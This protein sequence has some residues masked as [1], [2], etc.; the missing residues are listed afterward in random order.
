MGRLFRIVQVVD[1][2]A[3]TKFQ[4][5]TSEYQLIVTCPFKPKEVIVSQE[6]EGPQARNPLAGA[7]CHD[8]PG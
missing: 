2:E 6:L 1:G 8:L 5:L 4:S 7:L 3:R